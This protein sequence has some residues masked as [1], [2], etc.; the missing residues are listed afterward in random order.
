M[1]W[2]PAAVTMYSGIGAFL[3]SF[4]ENVGL[5]IP[6][7]EL[8]RRMSEGEEIHLLDLRTDAA[9]DASGVMNPGAVRVRPATF[10]R[11]AHDLPKD[12]ELV[13]CCT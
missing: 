3:F 13:F 11:V 10:H 4:A 9:C 6:A 2:F 1:E 7:E 5:P 12:R 8:N